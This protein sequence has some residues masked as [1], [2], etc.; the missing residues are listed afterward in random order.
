[1]RYWIIA[2][3]REDMEH[4]LKIG[5]YGMNRK[6]PLNKVEKGDGIA[7]Y[8]TKDRKIIATGSVTEG[9][10]LD[11]AKIFKKDGVFP[12]RIKFK[13]EKFKSAEEFDFVS[14]VD[15]LKLTTNIVYWSVYLRSG[16]VEI[17]KQDWDL[18][19]QKTDHLQRA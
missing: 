11:D 7:C 18:I 14:I 2:L 19:K 1:L 3:P 10:Y 15:Q 13:A 6:S 8:V 12:D 17:S 4:C 9:Y 16:F 5:A